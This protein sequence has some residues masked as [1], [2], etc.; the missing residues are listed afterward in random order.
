VPAAA[1][2]PREARALAPAID[3]IPASGYAA[4]ALTNGAQVHDFSFIGK[5]YTLA[6]IRKQR[7]TAQGA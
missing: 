1:T 4:Q 6:Q 7:R 5:P 3:I 2:P